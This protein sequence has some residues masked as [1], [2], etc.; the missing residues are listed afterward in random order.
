MRLNRSFSTDL[1]SAPPLARSGYRSHEDVRRN[2]LPPWVIHG[3]FILLACQFAYYFTILRFQLDAEYGRCTLAQL[4]TYRADLPFQY[5]VLTIWIINL[6]SGFIP[7]FHVAEQLWITQN[8]PAGIARAA[9]AL[10]FASVLGVLLA[11]RYYLLRFFRDTLAGS[12][13]SMSLFLALPWVYLL[14]RYAPYWAPYDIPALLITILGLICLSRKWRAAYYCV[15]LVGTF[16][17]ET[18]LVLTLAYAL[19]AFGRERTRTIAMHSLSQFAVWAGV[20]YLL[21]TMYGSNPTEGGSLFEEHLAANL[22]LL[23]N[24]K[25]YPLFLSAVAIWW[26]PALAGYRLIRERF[27]KRAFLAALP[28]LGAAMLVGSILEVRI[29]GEMLAF[30]LPA[31]ILALRGLMSGNLLDLPS[32]SRRTSLSATANR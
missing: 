3:A 26:L 21:F 23:R 6:L 19:E 22:T 11:F 18:T 7:P 14:P 29:F 13:M 1:L 9:I 15:F 5:R 27:V 16:N 4:T 12:L 10:E 32:D 28:F 24:P 20:K 2:A 30:V 17:R 8:V 31:G 25:S